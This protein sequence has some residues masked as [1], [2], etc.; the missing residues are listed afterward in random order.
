MRHRIWKLSTA[1]LAT[2]AAAA[3]TCELTLGPGAEDDAPMPTPAPAPMTL[4]T[5]VPGPVVT[6][7]A[8]AIDPAI[9]PKPSAPEPTGT[10]SAASI[11]KTV[12]R[13]KG[14]VS[15]CSEQAGTPAAKMQVSFVIMTD[16]SVHEAIEATELSDVSDKLRGCWISALKRWKFEAPKGGPARATLSL[17]R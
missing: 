8:S 10:L 2:L 7:Q 6:Q 1:L 4:P 12:A 5:N 3:C 13:H 9:K 17:P 14:E 16:G 11:R 15:F